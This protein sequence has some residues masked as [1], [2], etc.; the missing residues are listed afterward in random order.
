M[1]RM[2][3]TAECLKKSLSPSLQKEERHK[4]RIVD[5]HHIARRTFSINELATLQLSQKER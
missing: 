5:D 4:L 3:D 2:A 1:Q